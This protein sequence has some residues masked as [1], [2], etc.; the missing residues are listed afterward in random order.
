MLPWKGA[1]ITYFGHELCVAFSKVTCFGCVMSVESLPLLRAFVRFEKLFFLKWRL[2][3]LALSML[4]WKGARIT[5][6]DH[7]L[8]ASFL[9]GHM[10]WMYYVG[11]I[12][13][14][15]KGGSKDDQAFVTYIFE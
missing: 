8:Y 6:F 15:V 9:K 10:L 14:L 11:G 2:F 7:K 12:I 13:A 4:P 1:R 5:H 3:F